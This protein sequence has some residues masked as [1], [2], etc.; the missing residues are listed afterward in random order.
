MRTTMIYFLLFLPDKNYYL[1][2]E[3]CSDWQHGKVYIARIAAAN[4]LG[5]N[6][7]RF[8]TGKAKNSCLFKKAIEVTG[9]ARW[10]AF[11]LTSGSGNLIVNLLLQGDTLLFWLTIVQPIIES[12]VIRW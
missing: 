2:N 5:K 6:Q 1:K 4:A 10:I 11:C 12:T 3:K 7:R 9:Q 8:V